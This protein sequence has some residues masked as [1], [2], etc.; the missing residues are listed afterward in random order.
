MFQNINENTVNTAKYEEDNSHKKKIEI[1]SNVLS[2]KNI[3]IYVITFMISMVGVTGEF[4]PFSISILG[5][6]L[7]NSV[8]ALGVV[9]AGI[10]GS[11]IKFGVSGAVGY[12]LTVLTLIATM[13]IIKLKQNDEEKNEQI[14]FSKNILIENHDSIKNLISSEEGEYSAT[15]NFIIGENSQNNRGYFIIRNTAY[16]PTYYYIRLVNEDSAK[17]KIESIDKLPLNNK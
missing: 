13:F 7:A 11:A 5:A 4:S 17:W 15:I 12:I 8:P 1:F 6:C 14:K 9:L 3:I 16:S 10:I 2:I